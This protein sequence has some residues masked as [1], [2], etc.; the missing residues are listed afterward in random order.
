MFRISLA[1]RYIIKELVSS[2]L[3]C[4]IAL[5]VL[6][7]IGRGLQMRELLL[8][9]DLSLFDAGLLFVYMTPM[10][11]LI[12]VPLS[13][14][15]SVF[16]TFLR[17]STD[18]EL[19][20]L[21]AGGVSLYQLLAAPLLFC[22][23]CA[24]MNLAISLHGVSWGMG[25]FR[26]T[27]LEIANTRARVVIQPGIFNNDIFGLTLFARQVDPETQELKNVILEDRTRDKG[28]RLTIFAKRGSITTETESGSLL[29]T[30]RDGNMYRGDGRQFGILTF[31]TYEVRLDLSKVFAGMDMTDIRPKE[32]SIETL[33]RMKKGEENV[34]SPRFLRKVGVELE[35]RRAL[36]AA[37]VVLGLFSMP[38]ACM[39]EGVRRQMGVV[40]SLLMFLFYYSL[41][42]L[43]LNVSE[44][45]RVSPMIGL[46]APNLFFGLMGAIGLHFTSRERVP[47]FH[48]LCASIPFLRE[49]ATS[50]DGKGGNS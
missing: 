14:M 8:G 3:L 25:Q 4:F 35:K 32:L 50:K 38:L 24:I 16:L 19:V 47:T 37:C 34:P 48:S 27:V 20:A 2:F 11:M 5:L 13:C 22:T 12:V 29:F 31:N 41:F 17:M 10:F 23:V 6:I 39:F 40:L 28:N 26:N 44:S 45:G 36:P 30:L 33:Q 49:R 1:Q 46:W 9:L 42:S 21:K 43:G 7:L 15:L 18:R